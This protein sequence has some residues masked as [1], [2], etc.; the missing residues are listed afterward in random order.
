MSQVLD[1][2]S[3]A[4]RRPVPVS[5]AGARPHGEAAEAGHAVPGRGGPVGW[6]LG[7]APTLAVLALLGGVGWYGHHHGWS[8]PKFSTL[9][10]APAAA[11]ADWCETHA[12]PESQCVEC[13]PALLPAGPR[14]GW[15]AEHGVH[16]C[17]LHHPEVAELK[18]TPAVSAADL[19]RAERALALEDRERNNPLCRSHQR[20]IQFASVDAVRQAGVDVELVQRGPVREAVEG[21]GAI[22]Y[23]PTRL[24][25]LSS[26]VPGTV[27]RVFRNVGD[28]VRAGEVLA[29]V[30]AVQVG[31]AKTRLMRALAEE[32]LQRQTVARLAKA[33]GAIAGRQVQEAEAALAKAGA[34][35]ISAEQSL[36]NLGLPIDTASWRDLSERQ[37]LGRLRFLGLP[38]DVRAALK[39]D[40]TTANLVPV[41]A[42]IDGVVVERQVVAGEVVDAERVTFRVADTSRMW[43]VL[44]V[45]LE[46]ADQLA[47]GQP[48]RFRP[49]GSRTAVTGTLEWISTA[50]DPHTRMV[51]ARAELA[52]PDG[53]LR[54]ETF[55]AGEVVLRAE[56]DAVVVPNEAVHT[57]G[58]CRIVF[59]RG[60]EYFAGPDSPKVF[61]V[62]TVRLGASDDRYTEVIAGVLPGEVVATRGG[63]VLRA[64]LLKSSLGAG[65]CEVE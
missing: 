9:V 64:Q 15:C 12:V 32:R 30:D 41:T 35:V 53:R 33:R 19:R 21:S 14:H 40:T 57:D 23:D 18:E 54:D 51:R 7:S 22:T 36:G 61:H 52:N 44:S 1:H 3:Q 43:L 24:A 48:I 45:P 13:T 27:W 37:V 28:P 63:D 60:K 55:G 20:R 62:R 4:S 42:P 16:D 6:L 47:T 39:A 50:A 49:D 26:R 31:Q 10:G 34:G 17:P 58:C 11:P 25:S 59:V 2:P 46:Q 65:C 5:D 29:L 56:E 8:V 38:E